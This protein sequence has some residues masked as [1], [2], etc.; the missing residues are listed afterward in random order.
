MTEDRAPCPFCGN[1]SVQLTSI[2][3]GYEAWC[4]CG[5]SMTA[6]NPDSRN[7]VIAKWN[8]RTFASQASQPA[9]GDGWVMVPR[10]RLAVFQRVICGDWCQPDRHI[11]ECAEASAMLAATPKAPDAGEVGPC[12]LCAGTCRGHSL[13]D[14]ATWEPEAGS[15]AQRIRDAATPPAPNDDLRA[16]LEAILKLETR[17]VHVGYDHGSGGGN[18]VYADFISA[19]EAFAIARAAL[20]ENRRG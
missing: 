12:F 14:E 19:D 15:E 6:S 4:K 9:E 1:A 7:K 17:D 11:P 8:A 3:D 10:E 20:K 5:A 18:Y 2:R 16:A 13:V